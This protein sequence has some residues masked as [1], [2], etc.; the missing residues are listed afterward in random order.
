MTNPQV[1]ITA[2]SPGG[3]AARSLIEQLDADLRARY[4]DAPIF[5]FHPGDADDPGTVFLVATVGDAPVACG[6]FRRLDARTVEIK[7]MFVEPAHRRRGLARGILQALETEAAC[8]G[9]TTVRIET[10]AGQPEAIKLYR[11]AGYEPIEP[12]GEYV[13]N[14]VSRCFAKSIRALIAR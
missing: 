1:F 9:I 8:R 10:G 4:P 7:R 12:F 11:S 6:A 2:T 3:D 5:G 13:G 14:P